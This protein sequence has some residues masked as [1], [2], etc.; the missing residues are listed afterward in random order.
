MVKSQ[1]PTFIWLI[2]YKWRD[3]LQDVYKRRIKKETIKGSFDKIKVT[4][5][6]SWYKDIGLLI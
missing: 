1:L 5:N 4:E 2:Q 3:S 6:N